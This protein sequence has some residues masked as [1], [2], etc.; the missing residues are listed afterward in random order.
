MK[1]QRAYQ[2]HLRDDNEKENVDDEFDG[3]PFAEHMRFSTSSYRPSQKGKQSTERYS[4]A[5]TQEPR[6]FRPSNSSSRKPYRTTDKKHSVG[7]AATQP[8]SDDTNT[9]AIFGANGVTGHYFLQLAVE[10]G[11][12]VRA[13]LPP[14]V[15]LS[16][17]EGN[18]NVRTFTGTFDDEAKIARVVSKADYV[19]CMLHDCP[20]YIESTPTMESPAPRSTNYELMKILLPMLGYEHSRC[21][22]FLYQASSFSSDGKGSAP[23]LSN[24]VKKMTVRKT[25]REVLREQ[26]RI[27]KYIVRLSQTH[28]D[29][30]DSEPLPYRFIVTRPSEILWDR[31]SRK[32]LAASKSLPG[33][34]PITNIDLA[35]FSLNA[36][37]NEKLYDSCPYVVQD[38]I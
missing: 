14:G 13:L 6:A 12:K 29:E 17:F 31:P 38:G 27:I 4:T 3:M 37:K 9:V 16:D 30:E 21:K 5:S 10:A 11:Y 20:E 26:D 22:V 7:T 1:H 19:V 36:L 32:K 23:L 33:P 18:P 8:E 34:F 25:R 28:D 2:G 35:E 24:M 15:K